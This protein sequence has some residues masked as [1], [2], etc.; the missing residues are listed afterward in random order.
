MKSAR[1]ALMSRWLA[2]PERRPVSRI[3]WLCAAGR[4]ADG[5]V[6]ATASAGV[7]PLVGTAL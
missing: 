5:A 6:G 7:W 4:G 1:T 2:H 3:G